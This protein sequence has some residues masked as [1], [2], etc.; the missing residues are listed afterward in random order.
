MIARGIE[1]SGE[2]EAREN[3][4]DVHVP[5]GQHSGLGTQLGVLNASAQRFAGCAGGR[6]DASVFAEP[7]DLKIGPLRIDFE[8]L[9]DLACL[10]NLL[11]VERRNQAIARQRRN[12]SE[13]DEATPPKEMPDLD[14]FRQSF[15]SGH[16]Q[17]PYSQRKK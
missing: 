16:D 17:D 10:L 4:P 5:L 6:L 2:I 15:F 13:K 3:R 14:G 11:G 12:H 7:A 9:Q 1:E 8:V